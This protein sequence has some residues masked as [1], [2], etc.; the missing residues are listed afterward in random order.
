V[1]TR[2]RQTRQWQNGRT[3]FI[4]CSIWREYAENVAE[5]LTKGMRVV[6]TGRLA[7]RSYEH[8]GQRRTSLEIQVEEI[9]P[10][11]R[12]ARARVS[13][14]DAAGNTRQAP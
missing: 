4:R 7:V 10:C 9:G 13:R 5:T 14:V 6:V 3:L 11:L 2:T 1:R 8:N 12:Y